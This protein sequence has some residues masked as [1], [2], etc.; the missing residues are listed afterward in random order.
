MTKRTFFKY[1]TRLHKWAGLI[2]GIQILLWVL[3]GLF[4]TLFPINEIRGRHIAV[5]VDLPVSQKP[6]LSFEQALTRYSGEV[7][8]ASLANY[9]GNLAYRIEGAVGVVTLSAET[10]EPMLNLSQAQIRR[11]ALEYYYADNPIASAVFIT[12]NA[13][14]EYRRALPIWQVQ[15]DDRHHSRL[16][17]DPQ[18]AELMAVRTRLWR[19][20][21]VMWALHIMDYTER[22]RFNS[23]WLRLA[24][25][26]ALLFVL[27][28]FGLLMHRF[29]MR[30][31]RPKA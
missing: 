13:P 4:M 12:E 3:S 31:K 15:F 20:Y 27:S 2:I 23:W 16:Y 7:T 26:A 9:A 24:A 21:D 14:N 30:P 28:G 19:V 25:L 6:I 10:G 17:L 22:E 29:V 8:Q 11:M 5:Q 1:L 18:T